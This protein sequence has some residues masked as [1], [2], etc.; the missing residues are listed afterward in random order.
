MSLGGGLYSGVCDADYPLMTD[1]IANLKSVG[2]ATVAAAGNDGD[3]GGITAPGCISASVSVGAVDELDKIAYFSNGSTQIDL[4]APGT[5]IESS[6]PGGGFALADGTSMATPHVAG[7]WAILR[8]AYGSRDVD[9]EL[10]FLRT[11]GQPVADGRGAD[12]VTLP[13]LRLG[14][15]AGV[16]NP[17]PVLSSVS[18]N[19]ITAGRDTT[20]TVTGAGFVR[21]TVV[22]ADGVTLPTTRV[23]DTELQ[24]VLPKS[25]LNATA[26]WISIAVTSPPL[27]GGTSAPLVVAVLQP[28]VDVSTTTAA[29]SEVITATLS[30]GPGNQYDWLVL[31]PV[32][33]ASDAWLKMTFVPSGQ[34]GVV[35]NVR[36]PCSPC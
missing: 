24:A 25:M 16:V 1:A 34:T 15:A 35:W 2:I 32:G 31:V 3:P 7:A 22:I 28:E 10:D 12:V 8:Q 21:S 29:T 6:V 11:T 17:A 9:T 14:P 18:P 13:R 26:E 30:N 33:G 27:G 20:L 36:M 4:L 5:T 23:S 19:P